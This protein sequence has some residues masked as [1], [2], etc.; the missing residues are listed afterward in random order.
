VKDSFFRSCGASDGWGATST[1]GALL[2]ANQST[3]VVQGSVSNTLFADSLGIGLYYDVG[4]IM[5]VSHCTFVRNER[6][7]HWF[8]VGINM[9][10]LHGGSFINNIVYNNTLAFSCPVNDRFDWQG[11]KR[12]DGNIVYGNTSLSNKTDFSTYFDW[13]RNHAVDPHLDLND[14]HTGDTPLVGL[15]HP[16]WTSTA[17]MPGAGMTLPA[18]AAAL[19]TTDPFYAILDKEGEAITYKPRTGV[20]RTIKAILTR[21]PIGPGGPPDV[22]TPRMT[23]LCANH[24]TYGILR[25]GIDTGGDIITVPMKY[26]ETAGDR[27]VTDVLFEDSKSIRIGVR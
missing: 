10:R 15:A 2:F 13:T 20:S 5:N 17:V 1:G 4:T 9:E 12:W 19:D 23:A 11:T 8:S 26:G 3:A 14:E 27:Y 6:A 18:G 24:G 16:A 21:L 25:T 7:L 22:M